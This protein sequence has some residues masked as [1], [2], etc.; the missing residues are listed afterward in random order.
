MRAVMAAFSLSFGL[1][2][3]VMAVDIT[4]TTLADSLTVPNGDSQ[5]SLREAIQAVDSETPVDT[6]LAGLPGLD[7]ILFSPNLFSPGVLQTITLAAELTIPNVTLEIIGPGARQLAISGNDTVR[8]FEVLPPAASSRTLS[9]MTITRGRADDGGGILNKGRLTVKNI[10]FLDNFAQEDGGAIA[11]AKQTLQNPAPILTVLNCTFSGNG[12][13][14]AG[15]EQEEGGA[16]VN[17]DGSATIANSTFFGN[18]VPDTGGAIH[19]AG[20]DDGTGDL[21]LINSTISGNSATTGGAAIFTERG[22]TTVIRNSLIAGNTG[23]NCGLADLG[24]QISDQGGNLED[25]NTCSLGIDSLPNASTPGLD[26]GPPKNNGGSTDTIAL[27]SASDAI[28]L[29]MNDICQA[30]PV[31]NL[32]QRGAPRPADGDGD[33]NAFCDTGAFESGAVPPAG[34]QSPIVANPGT[35]TAV[36]GAN[37]SLAIVASDPNGDTLSFSAAGL[38]AGLSIHAG[39]GVVSGT[40]STAGTS[41]VTVTADDGHGGTTSVF[42]VWTVTTFA[43]VPPQCSGRTADVFVQDG[44]VFGGPDNG[45]PYGGLLRGTPGPDVMVGTAAA[46][47]ISGFGGNDRICGGRGRD[48]LKGGAGKD[49]LFGEGGKDALNGGGGSD[50]CDGGAGR[51]TARRCERSSNL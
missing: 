13:I 32:D 34:N 26:P 44:I 9:D 10:T 43:P 51:D 41:N 1:A 15:V 38:P 12:G 17:I 50:R 16:I 6:C 31:S 19:N 22:A 35:Q 40:L 21:T 37:A 39:T 28:D 33:G 2:G 11:N 29:G 24:S 8:V 36:V 23:T 20:N 7:R 3:P 42:F 25:A 4:V 48:S 14:A 5:C 49:R 45:L 30:A 47:S 46:D 27:T 18:S